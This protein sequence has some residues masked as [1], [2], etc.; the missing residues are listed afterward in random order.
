M[1]DFHFI[2]DV[3]HFQSGVFN[4]QKELW[5]AALRYLNECDALLI[6]ISD[7]PSGGRLIEVGI[8]YALN[9]PIIVIVKKGVKYK[10]FYDGI[11]DLIIE[12]ENIPDITALLRDYLKNI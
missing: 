3:E 9:K 4:D 11:A 5:E 10:D 1:N 6:D 7:S 8:A 12:Y 2:R